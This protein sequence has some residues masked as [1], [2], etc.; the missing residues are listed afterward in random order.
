MEDVRAHA[1]VYQDRASREAQNSE[2]LIQCLKASS[3]RAVYNKVYLQRDKYTN[4]RRHTGEPIKDGVCFL[5]TII[6]NY[7]SSTRSSTEQIR[8]QL[9]TLNYYMKNVETL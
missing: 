1:Q 7:H 8:K 3:S 4:Y 5:K 9:A 6:D 2:M